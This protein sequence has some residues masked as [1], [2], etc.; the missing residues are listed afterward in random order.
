M[1]SLKPFFLVT[2]LGF[3]LYWLITLLGLIPAAYLFKDYHNPLLVTWNWSFLPL[4]LLVSASGL[5]SLALE[6][7]GDPRWRGLALV[8]L[9]LT[10]CSGLQALAF[11]SLRADFDL[12]WWVPN[13]YLLIYPFAFIPR[14]LWGGQPA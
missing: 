1:R 12:A 3:I 13:L 9:V 8:S 5:G 10:A 6:R 11:W 14:L 4:D 7:R 2:D